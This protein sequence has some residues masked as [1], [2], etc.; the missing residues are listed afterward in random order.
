MAAPT[1]FFGEN[2]SPGGST[3][4]SPATARAAFLATLSGGVGTETFDTPATPVGTANPPLSFPGSTGSITATLNGS[5]SVTDFGGSAGR[6]AT[7]GRNWYET[8]SGGDFSISFS[9]GISAFGFYGTDIGDINNGLTLRMTKVSDGTTI[10]LAV[11]NTIGANNGSL[12]FFGF[13]DTD[14]AY[15]SIEFINAPGGGDVFGFDDMTV[16]DVTQIVNPPNGEVP[17]PA[18]GVLLLSALGG[19]A[20]LRRKKS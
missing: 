17:L 13:V 6:F 19:A 15:S 11:G 16:G 10:N 9:T 12:L 18:G 8:G 5:G 20:F 2:L 3:T 1:T 14:E 7:S 4:G